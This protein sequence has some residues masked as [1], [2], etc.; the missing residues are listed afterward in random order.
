ME[1]VFQ[2]IPKR[3]DLRERM[4][5]GEKETWLVTRYKDEMCKGDMVFFWLAGSPDIRGI[6]GW[7]RI[8]G[9]KVRYFENWGHGIEVC[10]NQVLPERISSEDLKKK[11]ALG[12]HVIFRMA[13][14][15]N[16]KLEPDQTKEL[17]ELIRER[18]GQEVAP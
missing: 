10:Y 8:V 18:F 5:K 14:G 17:C 16:F 1:W 11:K 4:N 2:A 9:D 3:Y 12:Q 7:G 6:Y 15:T 13:V